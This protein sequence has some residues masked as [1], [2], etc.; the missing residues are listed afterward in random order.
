MAAGWTDSDRPSKRLK[1]RRLLRRDRRLKQ[2]KGEWLGEWPG[3][4]LVWV[5]S[6]L[7]TSHGGYRTQTW[8]KVGWMGPEVGEMWEQPLAGT[9]ALLRRLSAFSAPLLLC[10]SSALS[11][12]LGRLASTCPG[13]SVMGR[14]RMKEGPG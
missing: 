10:T 11:C 1:Q 12:F 7:P 8:Q 13:L 2:A 5:A 3:E 9:P 6:L 14:S 4:H